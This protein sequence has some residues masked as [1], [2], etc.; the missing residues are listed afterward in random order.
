[1]NAIEVLQQAFN[2]D[3]NAIHSLICNRV[4]CN[5]TLAND[6]FIP[7]EKVQVLEN[8]YFQVGA[9]GLINGILAASNLPLVSLKFSEKDELGRSKVLGFCEYKNEK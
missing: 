3:P 1:M 7:V 4:P 5:E 8:A 2:S 9:L 6:E